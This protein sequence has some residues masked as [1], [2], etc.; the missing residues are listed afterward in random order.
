MSNRSGAAG[1]A[2]FRLRRIKALR[3]L[4]RLGITVPVAWK[5]TNRTIYVDL[6]R[7]FRLVA[8]GTQAIEN[9]ERRSFGELIDRFHPRVFWDIGANV[10]IYTIEFLSRVPEG[11]VVA[12]EPDVRNVDL[13]TRTVRRSG[14]GAVDIVAQAVGEWG[15]EATFLLDD[16]TG[17]TGTIEPG[18]VFISA[19][20]G[21]V[22]KAVQV[23]VTTLDDEVVGRAVPDIIKI[24][25]EGAE[26]AVMTGG[27]RMLAKHLS[28]IVYEAS[29]R[30]FGR[31]QAFLENLGYR[32]FDA[33]TL[34][35]LRAPANNVIALHGI[36]HLAGRVKLS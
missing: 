16:I 28:A 22:P 17:A 34:D 12:F 29:M 11:K 24:D 20:Y 5:P 19:Q 7:N 30:S 1:N 32:L 10:G 26:F 21:Q 3:W 13:L 25:V 2:I 9:D 14:F 6:M 36:K 23:R 35:P 18:H 33:S 4:W 27:R 8:S 15:G 31:T